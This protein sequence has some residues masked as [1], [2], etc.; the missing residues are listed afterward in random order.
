MI[1]VVVVVIALKNRQ[2]SCR[3]DTAR[4]ST[5]CEIMIRGR[6]RSLEIPMRW[7]YGANT[8]SK[9]SSILTLSISC[10]IFYEITAYLCDIA[11]FQHPYPIQRPDE[12]SVFDVLKLESIRYNLVLIAWRWALLF[13]HNTP[14][15]RRTDRQADGRTP[16][17]SI[18]P[19]MLMRR[20]VKP[21]KFGL[22]SPNY[23]WN[24]DEKFRGSFFLRHF[25]DYCH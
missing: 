12:G 19:A 5:S 16:H 9:S 8:R 23:G 13:R 11:I 7:V 15:D 2:L 3:R 14:C 21:V 6:S 20:A 18:F 10:A 1:A 25:V 22:K 4:R 24:I 17:H